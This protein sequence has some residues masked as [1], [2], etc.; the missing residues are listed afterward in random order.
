MLIAFN[1]FMV[2]NKMEKREKQ[3]AKDKLEGFGI[4]NECFD[5]VY[6]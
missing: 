2:L 4:G 5:L 3:W 6:V 1:L